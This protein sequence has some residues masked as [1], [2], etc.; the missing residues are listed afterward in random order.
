ML[1]YRVFIITFITL[2]C[3]HVQADQKEAI[4]LAKNIYYEARNQGI[5]GKLAVAFVTLNR[6][7]SS[8]YPE[9]ICEV[10]WQDN[11]FSWTHDGKPDNPYELEK[12]NLIKNL[13][14]NLLENLDKYQDLTKGSLH[15]HA[16]Y[17][18][19]C[20]SKLSEPAV[21]INNHL[22]YNTLI[23]SPCIKSKD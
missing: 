3:S 6:V 11:Q 23:G 7:T 2:F 17:V 10:V 12:Y 15:Y 22:F 9:T 13:T 14:S 16:D 5:E 21:I 18:T 1:Y 19:P 20:W 8:K 4:C